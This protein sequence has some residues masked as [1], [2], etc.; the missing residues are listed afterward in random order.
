M[1]TYKTYI[2]FGRKNTSALALALPLRVSIHYY[3][4]SIF[5]SSKCIIFGTEQ[6][7][8]NREKKKRKLNT[9]SADE[10]KNI[11]CRVCC[12]LDMRSTNKT[13]LT[14]KK[15]AAWRKGELASKQEQRY[16]HAPHSTPLKQH[17]LNKNTHLNAIELRV[18]SMPCFS[19]VHSLHSIVL[20]I[21]EGVV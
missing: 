14:E 21:Q 13:N 20:S 1:Y 12:M 2:T 5:A 10:K 11:M 3:Y 9:A 7:K 8:L 18:K 4:F 6:A 19:F 16:R 15:V 17:I